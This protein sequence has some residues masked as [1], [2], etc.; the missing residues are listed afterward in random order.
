MKI[1]SKEIKTYILNKYKKCQSD[2]DY[3]SQRRQKAARYYRGEVD[4]KADEGRSQQVTN[5]VADTIEWTKP[6]L[7]RTFYGSDKI[8][9]LKPV[10]A[11]DEQSVKLLEAKCTHD[12]MQKNKGFRI[13]YDWFT[14]ALIFDLGVIKYSWRNEIKYIHKE[15]NGLTDMDVQ[16]LKMTPDFIFEHIEATQAG[17]Y[18]E[19]GYMLSPTLYKVVGKRMKKISQPLIENVPPDEY[20]FDIRMRSINE[21]G[22][23][24]IHRKL[25]HVDEL[26]KYGLNKQDMES[27]IRNFS[28]DT[29]YQERFGDIGGTGFLTPDA[30]DDYFYINEAYFFKYDPE[31]GQIPLKATIIGDKTVSIEQNKYNGPPF[32]VL[33]PILAP[34]RMLGLSFMNVLMNTQDV[35]TSFLRNILDN[36]YTA[37]YGRMVY[38]PYRIHAEEAEDNRVGRNIRTKYDIDPNTAFAN[39]QPNML[40]KEVYHMFEE[41][42]PEIRT[43]ATGVTKHDQELQS[44]TVYKTASGVSQVMGAMQQ[45]KELLARIFGETGIKDLY[46]AVARMNTN[47]LDKEENIQLDNRWI[48]IKPDDIDVEYD[49]EID[50]GMSTGSK[51]IAFQDILA[52]FNTYGMIADK[53]GPATFELFTLENVKE[54]LK[55]LWRNKGFKNTSRFVNEGGGQLNA[56]QR[57]L[58]IIPGQGAGS[59][60]PS[61]QPN[62]QG[63]FRGNGGA[64]MGAMETRPIPGRESN[65]GAY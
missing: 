65:A 53:L 48:N 32:A 17:S 12:I 20:L 42:L 19:V 52:M 54:M 8:M 23:I 27:E 59:Q 15:Y 60:T 51:E 35:R 40:P 2:M 5:D 21:F 10:G 25:I 50:V 24:N 29:L 18:N 38:N 56:G 39:I 63:V 1:D 28:Q 6:F 61:R 43:D 41:V 13:H 58:P 34:H 4:Y 64:P 37:N 22:G 33:S 49:V 9:T 11:E 3:L 55:E 30:D 14:D 47:F 7:M 16:L 31:Y 44:K 57:Q 45:R 26:K 36:I 46:L 62:Y